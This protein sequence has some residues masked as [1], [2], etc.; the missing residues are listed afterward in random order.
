MIK[1]FYKKTVNIFGILNKILNK[2]I[3]KKIYSINIRL[4]YFYD[5]YITF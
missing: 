2:I 5:N 3:N 1:L 4:F